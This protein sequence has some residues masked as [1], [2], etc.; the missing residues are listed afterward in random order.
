[1]ANLKNRKEI[2]GQTQSNKL[3]ALFRQDFEASSCNIQIILCLSKEKKME[4]IILISVYQ[5]F[6]KRQIRWSGI[7]ISFRIFHSLL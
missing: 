1:M 6:L 7:S 5:A 2:I 4:M 3:S